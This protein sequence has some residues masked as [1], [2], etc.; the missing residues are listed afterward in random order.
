MLFLP[1]SPGEL[2]DAPPQAENQPQECTARRAEYDEQLEIRGLHASL[3]LL[4]FLTV[5]K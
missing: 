5:F 4:C 1:S 2:L 3:T